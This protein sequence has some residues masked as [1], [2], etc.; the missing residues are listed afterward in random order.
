[1]SNLMIHSPMVLPPMIWPV[2]V[3]CVGYSWAAYA[4]AWQRAMALSASRISV[5]FDPSWN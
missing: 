3:T 1:M 4:Y 5:P 2:G